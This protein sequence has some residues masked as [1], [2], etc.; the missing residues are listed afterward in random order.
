M[1]KNPSLIIRQCEVELKKI[2]LKRKNTIGWDEM[3]DK[4][5]ARLEAI[6]RVA[7][8]QIEGER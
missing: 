6:K 2:E 1:Y 3:F 4:E 7:E 8:K 5:V